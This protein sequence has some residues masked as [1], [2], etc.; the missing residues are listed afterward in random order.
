MELGR[1]QE[2]CF[3]RFYKSINNDNFDMHI[4]LCAG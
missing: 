1:E 3:Y 4:V 2:N